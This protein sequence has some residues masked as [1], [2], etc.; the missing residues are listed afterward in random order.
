MLPLERFLNDQMETVQ[1]MIHAD[2]AYWAG[3]AL[4]LLSRYGGDQAPVARWQK[5]LMM[6]GN[7]AAIARGYREGVRIMAEAAGAR[8][9]PRG[10]VTARARTNSTAA[11]EAG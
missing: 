5:S 6:P 10:M 1:R 9:V 8:T 11:A 4:G 2:D 3:Y 7:G